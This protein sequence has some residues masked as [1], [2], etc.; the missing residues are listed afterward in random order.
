[1]Y[2]YDKINTNQKIIGNII[3][4]VT[5]YN[6]PLM[7]F[8]NRKIKEMTF[9]NNYFRNIEIYKQ[10]IFEII[11]ASY[12]S[13]DIT[14][15]WFDCSFININNGEKFGPLGNIY[16]YSMVSHK[17]TYTYNKCEFI[18]NKVNGKGGA[19]YI[20]NPDQSFS[21]F[22]SIFVDNTA[23]EGG[24]VFIQSSKQIDIKGCTFHC[25]HAETGYSITIISPN[26]PKLTIDS[27]II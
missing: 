20:D 7:T 19:I 10:N 6:M 16:V 23:K 9:E 5:N 14:V 15:I 26:T 17:L 11:S 24:A 13:N 2:L 4:N 3:E 12:A 1:M 25:N 18:N 22:D 27:C 8:E 21:I